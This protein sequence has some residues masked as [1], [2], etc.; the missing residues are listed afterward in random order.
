MA[1]RTTGSGVYASNG[2]SGRCRLNRCTLSPLVVNATSARAPNTLST[3]AAARAMAPPG[4]RGAS[5]NGGRAGTPSASAAVM[6]R[7]IMATASIGW[8]PTP[9]SPESISASA[10]PRTALATSEASARVG[11]ECRIIDSSIWVAT[12][13]GFARSRASCTVRFCTS[14]TWA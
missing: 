8:A 4:V 6:I 12:I 7:A 10:P 14:G 13:V 5:V 3:L 2:V 9:V 1:E 11:R